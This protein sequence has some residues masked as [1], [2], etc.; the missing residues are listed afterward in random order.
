MLTRYASRVEPRDLAE[1]ITSDRRGVATPRQRAPR[2]PQTHRAQVSV[3]EDFWQSL[4]ALA[5]QAGTTPNDAL[6]QLAQLSYREHQRAAELQRIADERWAAFRSGRTQ[7][8]GPSEALS[9]DDLIAASRTFS[10]D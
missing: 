2:R 1:F 7:A 3:P 8:S 4:R 9:E 10:E 5:E 6:V